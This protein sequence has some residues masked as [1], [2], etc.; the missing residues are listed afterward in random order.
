MRALALTTIGRCNLSCAGTCSG[1]W[2]T[3]CECC[4]TPLGAFGFLL[5]AL[6]FLLAI[7]SARTYR[8]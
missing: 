3:Y 2:G 8:S 6:V 4:H 1:L 5:P 7:R